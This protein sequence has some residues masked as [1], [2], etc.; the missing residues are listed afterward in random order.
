MHSPELAKQLEKELSKLQG[1]LFSHR[2]ECADVDYLEQRNRGRIRRLCKRMVSRRCEYKHVSLRMKACKIFCH[3]RYTNI[4]KMVERLRRGVL[5][6]H[7]LVL[8]VVQTGLD[9]SLLSE[10]RG[11]SIADGSWDTV[12]MLSIILCIGDVRL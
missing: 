3:S 5:S 2:H 8:A 6:R 4:N 11:R 9:R 1:W 10:R 7:A 12:H